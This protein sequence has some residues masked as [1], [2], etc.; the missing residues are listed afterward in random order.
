MMHNQL[1]FE[2]DAIIIQCNSI[3]PSW[4]TWRP[5]DWIDVMIFCSVREVLRTHSAQHQSLLL[6]QTFYSQNSSVKSFGPHPI[7]SAGIFENL[8]STCAR[9][10]ANIPTHQFT[11]AFGLMPS[12][13]SIWELKSV[14]YPLSNQWM[15]IGPSHNSLQW[16]RCALSHMLMILESS[17]A[18]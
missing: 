14:Q 8:L 1:A 6:A 2:V 4:Q 3:L 12:D 5:W 17:H 11:L 10:V 16:L 13:K 9:N 18:Y 7:S 15:T